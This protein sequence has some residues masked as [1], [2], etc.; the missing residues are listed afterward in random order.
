M[1]VY[2]MAGATGKGPYRHQTANWKGALAVGCGDL[3]FHDTGDVN[4]A[5]IP[6][7]KTASQFAG[8]VNHATTQAAFKAV[9][10]G[11][12]EVRRTT[13][14]TADGSDITDGAILGTGEFTK[15]CTAL[16]TAAIVGA[17]VGPAQGIS[18]TTLSSTNV[19]IVASVSGAIGKLTRAAPV[20]ATELTF[21][22]MPATIDG[23]VVAVS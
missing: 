12:S 4:T 23:G 16:L 13:L 2:G 14:Q 18:A 1:G 15:P 22:V 19:E 6:Y 11:I 10:R 8:S 17:Y 9:F 20:G 21:E 7:D 3:V 5:S